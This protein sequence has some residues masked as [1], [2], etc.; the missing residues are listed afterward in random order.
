MQPVSYIVL[1]KSPAGQVLTPVIEYDG[2]TLVAVL[3]T[4]QDL[5]LKSITIT[6]KHAFTGDARVQVNGYQSWTDT[7]EHTLTEHIRGLRHVPQ[8]ITERFALD[9]MG[10]F[11]FIDYD[12]H[13]GC[14]H[15]FTYASI[16]D[17]AESEEITLVSSLDESKGFTLIRVDAAS[18]T[19]TLQTECPRGIIPA[20]AHV[21]LGRYAILRGEE[22]AVYSRMFELSGVIPRTQKPLC[23]YASWYRHYDAIDERKLIDDLASVSVVL[24]SIDTSGLTRVFQIDDGW[25]KVGDWM[26]ID[27][28]KFPHGV[29]PIASAARACGLEPG[30]WMAPFVCERRSQLAKE[31]PDWIMRN[32]NGRLVTTGS[33]WSGCLALDTRNEEVRDYVQRCIRNVVEK[34]GFELLKLDFLYAACIVPHNGLNRG[35]LMADAIA[36][37][38]EAAGEACSIIACGVPLGSAFGEVEYCRIGCDV[39][40]NWDNRLIMR[41]LHRERMSTKRGIA[42]TVGRSALN[43]RAF[44]NDP[45][46]CFINASAKLSSAKRNLLLDTASKHAGMLL[47]SDDMGKWTPEGRAAYERAIQHIAQRCQS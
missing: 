22:N 3:E 26:N 35:E 6:L 30:L 10:D 16:R 25:C 39:G 42:N 21:V 5:E 27:A 20:K 29:A 34:W 40:P 18:G 44:L 9:T 37:L 13:P 33:R 28:V 41:P 1:C 24:D 14:F 32:E 36:L 17:H 47:T 7:V 15:G 12:M 4:T 19:L 2:E 45:D 8:S 38:R 23:G 11:R 46:A 31:H 43:G